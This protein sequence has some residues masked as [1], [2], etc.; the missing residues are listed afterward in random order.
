MFQTDIRKLFHSPVCCLTRCST[1]LRLI[2]NR[3]ALWE[4]LEKVQKVCERWDAVISENRKHH[5]SKTKYTHCNKS[6]YLTG[7]REQHPWVSFQS[8]SKSSP[9]PCKLQRF[10]VIFGWNL[11]LKKS[12]S[13]SSYLNPCQIY[14]VKFLSNRAVFLTPAP[15]LSDNKYIL[16]SE[17][18]AARLA[19]CKRSEFS[20]A[21]T[22][23]VPFFPQ[24]L[25]NW[26]NIWSPQL[27]NSE[28]Q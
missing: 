20:E 8:E 23:N 21:A 17:N 13:C 28:I 2:P 4:N 27:Q 6:H 9:F 3:K 12:Q 25:C 24:F 19:G 11:D 10:A 22:E 1:H 18:V 7:D 15:K 5:T 26:V 16:V 14:F